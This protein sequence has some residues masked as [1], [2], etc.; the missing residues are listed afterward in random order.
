MPASAVRVCTMHDFLAHGGA[1]YV[2]IDTCEVSARSNIV[3]LQ[4]KLAS[5][6][7]IWSS[8][9]SNYL[10]FYLRARRLYVTDIN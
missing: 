6:S 3:S 2:V 4:Y 10:P 9:S 5:Q 7:L 1:R 8:E